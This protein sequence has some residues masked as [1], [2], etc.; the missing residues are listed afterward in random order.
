MT[1]TF[2][3]H[4]RCVIITVHT[5]AVHILHSA[6]EK[7]RDSEFIA[8][9]SVSANLFTFIIFEFVVNLKELGAK[10]SYIDNN[11]K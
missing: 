1:N 3:R 4:K 10:L 8:C 2:F 11:S 6:L 9:C 7:I 5:Q